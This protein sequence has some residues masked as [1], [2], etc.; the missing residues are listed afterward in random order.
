MQSRKKIN[1]E[2]MLKVVK[3]PFAA[4]L[5]VQF[6]KL[7]NRLS[8]YKDFSLFRKMNDG[9]LSAERSD[10]APCLLDNT[11]NTDFEPHYTF[12]PAWA[13]RVLAETRPALHI[14]FSSY[15]PFSTLVS[16]F[17]PIHFYDYRPAHLKLSNLETKRGDL[18][19]MPFADD[20]VISLSCMHTVEHV[21][22]GRYG[23]PIDPEGD[24]KAI[25]ELKRVLAKGG[26]LLFV[27]PMGRPRVMFNANRVYSYDQIL[28][29]FSGLELKEFSLIPDDAVQ[30]GMV[31]NA[32]KELADAQKDCC[33]CFWFRK[34]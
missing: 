15:L 21:G 18:L 12:H 22:L 4:P 29:Y 10:M 11:E 23:D 19:S 24:L 5:Y 14:D 13:A 27:V 1:R 7:R 30:N 16:A 3:I 2:L 33:G 20:S 25:K 31:K 6:K 8:Y 34:P 28:G 9:R 32:S 26:D 17:I